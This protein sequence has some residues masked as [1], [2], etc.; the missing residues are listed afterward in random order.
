[1]DPRETVNFRF[2]TDRTFEEFSSDSLMNEYS[3]SIPF[4]FPKSKIP[5]SH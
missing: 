4:D 3:P 1:M 5:S 2:D